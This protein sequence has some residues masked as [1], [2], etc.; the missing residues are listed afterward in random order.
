MQ[1]DGMKHDITRVMNK[2]SKFQI[3]ERSKIFA[4]KYKKKK[5]YG[6]CKAF[7][8]N[9]LNFLLPNHKCPILIP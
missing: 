5:K 1:Y 2:G 3:T 7:P 9:N 8:E 4:E 6:T